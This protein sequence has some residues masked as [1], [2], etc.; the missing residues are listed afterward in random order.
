MTNVKALRD[1]NSEPVAT[2]VDQLEH[3]LELARRGELRDV[4]IVGNL[5]GNRTYTAFDTKDIP[6]LVGQLAQIQHHMLSQSRDG[7]VP[8]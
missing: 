4:C 8:A 3:A 2:V 7:A 1:A 6:L 5:T